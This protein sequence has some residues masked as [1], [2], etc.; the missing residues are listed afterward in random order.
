LV[1]RGSEVVM[2]IGTPGAAG[3]TITLAQVLAR[4]LGRREDVATAIA[5]PRWSVAPSGKVILEDNTRNEVSAAVRAFE[6]SLQLAPMSHVRFGSIKA[7]WKDGDGTLSAAA[8]YRR[9]A[10]AAAR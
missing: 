1:R 9:V 3:Q 5:A 6:P 4:I 8:D 7:V 10:A 2:A